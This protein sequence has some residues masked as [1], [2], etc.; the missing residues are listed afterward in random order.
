M[1]DF[2]DLL[3]KTLL[4]IINFAYFIVLSILFLPSFLIVSTL[5]KT[6]EEALKKNLGI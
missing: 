2:M 4:A 6:W 5:Q 1:K 3:E